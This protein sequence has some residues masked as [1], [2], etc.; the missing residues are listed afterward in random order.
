VL[1][2]RPVLHLDKMGT[3]SLCFPPP[4]SHSTGTPFI[5]VTDPT[6]NTHAHPHTL[7]QVSHDNATLDLDQ[8]PDKGPHLGLP[9]WYAINCS[10][11]LPSGQVDP[12]IPSTAP[13]SGN[14]VGDAYG[15]ASEFMSKSTARQRYGN[16]PIAFGKDEG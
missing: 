15:L 16:G 2:S 14:A 8:G 10:C 7:V 5:L 12:L 11:V 13:S 1:F 6:K 4:F 9:L 3:S